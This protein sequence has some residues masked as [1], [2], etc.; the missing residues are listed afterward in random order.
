MALADARDIAVSLEHAMEWYAD[1][2]DKVGV[3]SIGDDTF[4]P[5]KAKMRAS[6]FSHDK[7]PKL[8]TAERYGLLQKH[9]DRKT[10]YRM[11][12]GRFAA[13]APKIAIREYFRRIV[14][15]SWMAWD[16]LWEHPQQRNDMSCTTDVLLSGEYGGDPGEFELIPVEIKRTLKLHAYAVEQCI[17]NMWVL[18]AGNGMILTLLDGYRNDYKAY[19]VRREE[20]GWRLYDGIRPATVENFFM[21]NPDGSWFSDEQFQQLYDERVKWAD[22]FAALALQHGNIVLRALTKD[23]NRGRNVWI[24][25][26]TV[27]K[28]LKDDA[29]F[30]D[31][32]AKP[33]A[34]E[35]KPVER[36]KKSGKWGKAGDVKRG[37]GV[38]SGLC[39]LYGFCHYRALQVA[40]LPT[41]PPPPAIAVNEDGSFKHWIT[42]DDVH[43]TTEDFD[44]EGY[45]QSEDDYG[46]R[47]QAAD[48][49]AS[50]DVGFDF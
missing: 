37:S 4:T 15:S 48:P 35:Y 22:K 36:Y 23:I 41:D 18:G 20:G 19:Y 25:P 17:A 2:A 16:V 31:H 43:E 45:A 21:G 38:V 40:S 47:P 44:S 24:G 29:P 33:C 49:Q 8:A 34:Q 30:T 28:M 6:E 13:L 46:Q 10:K 26:A 11:L 32:L 42:E 50:S 1:N 7:C 12:M 14:G 5:T 3:Y 39:P 9:F 27:S